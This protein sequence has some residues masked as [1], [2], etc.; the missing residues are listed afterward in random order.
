MKKVLRAGLCLAVVVSG[1]NVT[2]SETGGAEG[3]YRISEIVVSASPNNI[4]ENAGTIYRVTAQQIK[5]QNAHTLDEALQL[6]PGLIVREGAEGTPRIDMRGFRTR[7]VQFFING[8]PLKSS[9]DGQFDPTRIPADIISEIK[10][11]AGGSSV[12][13][14][15][16]GNGGAIDIITKAGVEGVHG[17][18]GA[19]V[20]EGPQFKGNASVY[21]AGERV[22][23][24]GNVSVLDRDAYP[25]S[26]DFVPVNS[27]WENGGDRE[28]SDRQRY[29]IFTNVSYDLS[30]ANTLGFT[31]SRLTGE[32]GSKSMRFLSQGH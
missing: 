18:V 6:V 15:A 31:F 11:T 9:Y 26:S 3:A 25:I 8:I 12:L 14:G 16:G 21:G 22:N 24:Y 10:V 27:T 29:S 28:N 13:Y 7:H 23:F 17:S 1:Q 32:N 30:D 4:V 19:E 20:L 2:A 5:D